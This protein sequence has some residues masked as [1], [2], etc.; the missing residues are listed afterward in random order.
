[1]VSI[2]IDGK[3]FEV[4]EGVNVLEAALQN[5][6]YIPHLCHH[7]DLP[8]L[9]SCRLC[10]VEVEGKEGVFTSCTLKAEDGLNIC[11]KSEKIN[12]LRKLAMELLLAAHPEDCSTCP[13]YGRCEFQTLIQYMEV[14]AAR[15]RTRVKGFKSNE[16]NPLLI[17][18]MN[19]C[20]LCGR[21]VRACND[22]RGAKVLKYNK[23]DMETYVGTLHDKLL[24]DSDCRFC[25]ACAEVCPT[26]T[27]RDM[28]N[29][30]PIEKHDTLIPCEATCPVHTNI[31][32]YLR[33]TKEGKFAEATAVIHERLP[34]P[35]CLGRVCAHPCEG[36]C[37]R[38][39][40]NEA[41]SIRDIKRYAAEHDNNK[42]WKKNSKHLP[43][44]GK[45]V[46]VVGGGPAGLAAAFYLAKQ[47]H[48][49]VLKEAY[50]KLGGQMQ[51]GI[52]AYR[53]PREIVDKEANYVKEVGVK[54]EVNTRVDEPKGLLKKFDAILMAIGTHKG[55][56]LPMEG[57]E[58][59]G[60]IVN[61]EFLRKAS[62][63]E[64]TGIGKHVIVLGGGNVA[65]DCARTAKRLGAEEIHLACLEKREVMLADDEEIKEAGE[66][67]IFVHPGQTFERIVGDDKVTGVAFCNVKNF[68]FDENR[69][70]IIEK[71]PDSEHIINADTVIFAV[72]QR[73]AISEEAGLKLGRGNS[74][75]VEIGK[76]AKTSVEGI[77]ACGD[78]VYGTKTVVGAVA[79]GRDA[80]SEIDRYLGGDGDI[81]EVLAPK[82]K[83]TSNIGR[84]EKFGY[85]KRAKE[86]IV[87]ADERKDNFNN[88][89][90]GLCSDDI[91]SEAG[92][93]LQ[94]DLRFDITKHRVWS[95]YSISNEVE[96]NKNAD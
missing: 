57:N 90:K 21:C 94:C 11:T 46:C 37:R 22:L 24:K 52:P 15:M 81:S 49:V 39:E 67:G 50:P 29:Y 48:E 59:D 26:G 82:D 9:G 17:H 43:S 6:I 72:G 31:P 55:V 85:L 8:E 38:G 28:L 40:V 5:G 53:L 79:A 13:K 75:A 27:I 16:E 51:Y 25:G 12:R 45:K 44:T 95:D 20:V 83:K 41:V 10:V 19:R 80:A 86:D 30:S 34:F 54:V 66:E 65:F 61:T 87:Q 88:V 42:L 14:S 77:F 71:E 1:M 36:K 84:I 78:A 70:A 76:S 73:T 89:N 4:T 63:G 64:N 18:D 92:R 60:V 32:R 33:F 74:I 23:K 68:S 69:R 93:C 2:T 58:L 35:E 96:A 7:P 47:G 91:C 3:K 62:M 56:R